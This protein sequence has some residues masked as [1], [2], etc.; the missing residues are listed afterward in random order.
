MKLATGERLDWRFEASGPVDFNVHY[1]DGP[2]VVMPV[3]R[4]A[5]LGDAGIYVAAIPHDYCAMWEAGPIGMR[6]DY[7]VRR[8]PPAR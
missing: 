5:S 1:H 2:S 4:Q 6:L 7:R 3:S 8:L